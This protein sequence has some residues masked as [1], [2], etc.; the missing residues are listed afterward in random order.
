[1]QIDDNPF[2]RPS[3]RL[4]DYS[5]SNF[6]TFIPEGRLVSAGSGLQWLLRGWEMFRTAPGTWIGIA[7]AFMAVMLIAGMLPLLNILANLLIPV[8]IGGISVGCRAIEEGEGIRFEHLFAGFSRQPGGLLMVGLLYLLALLVVAVAVGI[9]AT[10]T[11]IAALA[12]IGL[13]GAGSTAAWA[14][15]VSFLAMILVFAPLAMAVWLAPPLLL[16]HELSAYQAIK[17]GVLVALR[18][19]PSFLVYVLLVLVAAVLASLPLLLGWLVL[20]PVLYASL[21]AAYRELFFAE[22]R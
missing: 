16:F 3:A 2:R 14:V 11:G 12:T 5:E 13:D 8:F 10:V 21:Y 17:T 20:L 9:I 7:V 4:Y 19:F 6:G 1:M 18:N 22:H 15:V